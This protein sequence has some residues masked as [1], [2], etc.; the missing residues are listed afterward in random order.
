MR[1]KELHLQAFGLFT[2][3][4]LNFGEGGP[5]CLVY[6]LNEAGK[7]TLLRAIRDFFFGIPRKTGDAFFH[8]AKKL[9]IDA[10]LQTRDGQEF[11]LTRRRGTKNTLL[12][13]EG[14]PVD[15]SAL[16]QY[17]GHIGPEVFSTMFGMDHY[18]LRR[19]GEDLLQGQGALGEVLFEAASGIGG[20]RNLMREL[21]EEAGELFKP[22]GSKPP[23]NTNMARYK[24][25]KSRI[26]ELSMPPQQWTEL[27]E[28]YFQEKER[29]AKLKD[30]EKKLRERKSR[31]ER[32]LRTLPLLAR[33]HRCLEELQQLADT[34]VLPAT[35]KTERLS[36]IN[37]RSSLEQV[38]IRAEN[39]IAELEN[40]LKNIVI[41]ED[42]LEYSADISSLQER[43]DTYRGYRQEMPVLEGEK[44]ELG[45]EAFSLLRRLNPALNSL[46]Q[47]DEIAIP[48]A[49]AVEI[50]ELIKERPLLQKNCDTAAEK[51]AELKRS[52][53]H[54]KKEKEALGPSRDVTELSRVLKRARKQGGLEAELKKNRAAAEA[55]EKKLENEL[56][57]L[58]LFSG[59][60]D[61]LSALPLPLP[62]TVRR[63]EEQYRALAEQAGN[64]KAR[65][66]EEKE[67]LEEI[68]RQL[69]RLEQ[70]GDVPTVEMLNEARKHR[71]YGWQLIRRAWLDGIRDQEEE[72]LFD[73]DYPLDRAFELSMDRA[74]AVADRLR[75]E[76]G[77]VERKA[78]LLSELARVESKIAHLQAELDR[79]ADEKMRL[80]RDWHRA[81]EQADLEPLTPAEMLSWLERCRDLV[82]GINSLQEYRV[83]EQELLQKINEQRAEI[84]LALQALG[85]K[86]AGSGESLAKLMDRAE[87]LVDGSLKLAASLQTIEDNISRDLENLELALEQKAADERVLESWNNRWLDALG[88]AA[89]PTT[90]TP[91]AAA[92][93]LE[94]LEALLQKKK[95]LHRQEAE[96]L[97][98]K[99]Y[100]QQFE[101][102]VR[103]LV[104]KLDPAL[105]E[106]P[107]DLAVSQ[108]Q[109]RAAGAQQDKTAAA[110][111]E[112]QLRKVQEERKKAI[113]G[114]EEVSISIKVLMEQACCR[115]EAELEEAEEKS[116]R[117]VEIRGKLEEAERELLEAGGGKS[118]QQIIAETEGADADTLSAALV[119]VE[120]EL[121]IIDREQEEINQL[122]GATKKEYEEKKDGASIAVVEAAE[123]AQS[124][125]AE[126]KVQ[127]EQ[128]L[129]LRLA[130]ILLRRGIES[131]RE[132]NQ[133]PIIKQAGELFA[134]LTRGSF[135]G[136]KV[137]FDEKDN[138]VLCG[139]R[140]TGEVVTVNGM[141]EGTL[142]Q[143]YLSLRLAGLERY[144]SNREP[145][146]LIL[147]DLLVNFDDYRAAE[148]LQLLGEFTSK[149][150]ILFF[151]HHAS[152]VE[153][154]RQVI[155]AEILQVHTIPNRPLE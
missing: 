63:F 54:K 145:L 1:I 142:D 97:K 92:A 66:K 101:E 78:A 143:L 6:G 124:V 39:E 43:L 74:D 33:R 36:S 64:T 45:E 72:Q 56:K 109:A 5:F 121:Q 75:L 65:I 10:V 77:R 61:K 106:L 53:S 122:F 125:L 19:G 90:T 116:A 52:I 49:L 104:Q 140:P 12:N 47:V 69:E 3:F 32:Q 58:G 87:D 23:L 86:A 135:A 35:F 71:N 30:R 127:T 50:K 73:P 20:L 22:S 129:R 136:I 59:P 88:R 153:L 4:A 117:L 149:T 155:P 2:D 113:E 80:D 76:A 13:E 130:S 132:E 138:P 11:R 154:A 108:L 110:H 60:L 68:N 27:E 141:S 96:L 111:L 31:L 144:L 115:E 128:Y 100:T 107:A 81:W 38:K 148:T 15:E 18:S 85:E 103:Q 29:L 134:R 102:Q 51:V 151:T 147:D 89:L 26:V 25:L 70:A 21:E 118:L 150:Q 8:P 82:N 17:L 99:Q 137:D 37:R 93:Y 79:L 67:R 40:R 9:R 112:E 98:R 91:G 94:E 95:E 7:T 139:L 34:A 48:L 55:L 41:Q 84:G 105:S 46:A 24:S 131:Y 119:E 114:L 44:K 152:L 83:Q 133:S 16:R 120:Q 62:E 146:P 14:N 42:L 57:S 28:K 126:L 123:E